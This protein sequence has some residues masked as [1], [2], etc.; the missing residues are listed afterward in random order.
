MRAD[1]RSIVEVTFDPHKLDQAN[2]LKCLLPF[3]VKTDVNAELETTQFGCLGA[4]HFLSEIRALGVWRHG[5]DTVGV[6]VIAGFKGVSGL[7]LYHLHVKEKVVGAL[8]AG[9]IASGMLSLPGFFSARTADVEFEYWQNAD[10][11][12]LY[13]WRGRSFD[14]KRLVSNGLPFP[15]EERVVD[16]SGNP[17]RR[18]FKPGYIE[19]VGDE[20]WLSQECLHRLGSPSLDGLAEAGWTVNALAGG[21]VHL[22][23]AG[24]IFVEE[25]NLELQQRLRFALFGN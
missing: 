12:C 7:N 2:L 11:T 10:Q 15:L 3:I 18:Q 21:V 16:I 20:M 22:R 23:T 6:Q 14:A 8:D 25:A 5:F 13:E 17:G 24:E 4:A 9:Q 19:A 1:H